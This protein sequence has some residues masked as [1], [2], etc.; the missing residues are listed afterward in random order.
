[1]ATSLRIEDWHWEIT[2]NCNQHCAH[3]IIGDLD[4]GEINTDKAAHAITL[5]KLL[6]GKR[7]HITG[8]EPFLRKDLRLLTS[9]AKSLGLSVEIITNGIL[10]REIVSFAKNG[11]LNRLGIS[12]D[13]D[14]ITH[15]SIRGVG[16][17]KKTISTLK[18]IVRTGLPI[19]VY[20][21]ITSINFGCI[22]KIISDL[23]LLGVNSFH[24]NEVN[25][26]G[27][28]FTNNFLSV[29]NLSE[30]EK[31]KKIFSQLDSLIEIKD[32]TI[33]RACSV[34]PMTAYVDY[35]GNVYSCA[36]LAITNSENAI[37][38]LFSGSFSQDFRRYHSDIK[39][40][41]ECRYSVYGLP[42][43]NICLNSS[44]LCPLRAGGLT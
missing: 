9:Q 13:G 5:M 4:A 38:N 32:P 1:M 6:G 41:K 24:L 37:A 43:I 39:I 20:I 42:G 34:S 19:T 21:T 17:Y 22:E 40:P 18:S 12:I 14:E 36:E 16:S 44:E 2:R 8:G 7:L 26:F 29:N 27:R 28:A 25:Q 30:Y 15:D 31:F 33:D 23:I 35:N 11:L 10:Q 3:C